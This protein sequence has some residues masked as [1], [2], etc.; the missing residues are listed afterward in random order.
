MKQLDNIDFL[1]PAY[2]YKLQEKSRNSVRTLIAIAFF[3][4]FLIPLLFCVTKNNKMNAVIAGHNKIMKDLANQKMAL[5]SKVNTLQTEYNNFE[6]LSNLNSKKNYAKEVSQYVDKFAPGVWI[7]SLKVNF[8]FNKKAPTQFEGNAIVKELTNLDNLLMKGQKFKE[9]IES[10][11]RT[12]INNTQC[13]EL[14]W[15]GSQ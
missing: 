13:V 14:V 15:K 8:P 5:I 1:T 7:K 6:L 4:I 11:Q 10:T 12:V 2:T 9:K 3:L